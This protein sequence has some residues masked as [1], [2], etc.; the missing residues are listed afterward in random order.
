MNKPPSP[1]DVTADR[2]ETDTSVVG[3][4]IER[5]LGEGAGAS[6]DGG[7]EKATGRGATFDVGPA[8]SA[9]VEV[10]PESLHRPVE[11]VAVRGVQFWAK[12]YRG[13]ELDAVPMQDTIAEDIAEDLAPIASELAT[14][15]R[16]T[17]G[18]D[19]TVWGHAGSLATTLTL[20]GTAVGAAVRRAER[21]ADPGVERG[22]HGSIQKKD[23]DGDED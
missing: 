7:A 8:P 9:R 20:Y 5:T 23:G 21:E 13:V 14:W 12:Q 19:V 3:D 10:S 16:D 18:V 4:E 22:P 15:I 6:A 1:D 17:F 11:V 2:K